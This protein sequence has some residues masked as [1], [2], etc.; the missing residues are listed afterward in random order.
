M[1]GSI[2]LIPIK[3]GRGEKMKK[4]LIISAFIALIAAIVT[5]FIINA[6]DAAS[7][8]LSIDNA[9]DY[10]ASGEEF[11]VNVNFLNPKSGAES[12]IRICES[13]FRNC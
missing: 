9:K 6:E 5:P 1:V 8:Q 11:T 4:P 3:K 12:L 13:Y 2:D 10:Y 7:L